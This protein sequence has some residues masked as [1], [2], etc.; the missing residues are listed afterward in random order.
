MKTSLKTFWIISLSCNVIFLLAQIATTI[1]LVLYKNALHL[2]NSD[3]SQIFFG[4]LIIIILTMFIS[5]WIIVR[6]PLRKLNKT[7]ELN[8]EQA[9]LGF[10]IITK[11]SHL[12]T[13]YDGYVWYLK[14]KGFILL[15]TLGINFS[16]ALITAVIFSI[17]G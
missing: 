7:K 5:N 9:D 8:P 17:L 15:T 12:Q 4:I 3:L 2:S 16:Y 11:Y 14:K 10:N 13:E 1:P 6:N